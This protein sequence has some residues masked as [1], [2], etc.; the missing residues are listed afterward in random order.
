MRQTLEIH[1]SGFIGFVLHTNCK[2]DGFR[3]FFR[4]TFQIVPQLRLP[5]EAV[6]GIAPFSSHIAPCFY[7]RPEMWLRAAVTVTAARYYIKNSSGI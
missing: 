7:I 3:S 2:A 1:G 6:G 5:A 4:R